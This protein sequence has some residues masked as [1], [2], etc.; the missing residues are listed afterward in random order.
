MYKKIEPINL[1][2]RVYFRY[3]FGTSIHRVLTSN[4]SVVPVPT[5]TVPYR[6]RYIRYRYPLLVISVTKVYSV[7][8]PTFGDFGNCWYR[9]H[10]IL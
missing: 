3:R 8:V 4:T 5:G 6:T 7:P 10:Q 1:L 2:N 9:A